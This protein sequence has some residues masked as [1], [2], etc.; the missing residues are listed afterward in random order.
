MDET[1]RCLCNHGLPKS[2][3][4]ETSI[5]TTWNR[6]KEAIRPTFNHS[7]MWPTV[8]SPLLPNPVT[9]IGHPWIFLSEIPAACKMLNGMR[10]IE[11]PV[12]TKALL[13]GI[14]FMD[15]AKLRGLLWLEYPISI[16]SLLKVISVDSYK[17]TLSSMTSTDKHSTPTLEAMLT[18]AFVA[19]FLSFVIS[20]N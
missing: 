12:S 5:F 8:Y 6:A 18:K 10:F 16:S 3:W 17:R 19:I 9:S 13:I 1:N 11:T 7:W 4:Y 15:A 2:T 20:S 14:W